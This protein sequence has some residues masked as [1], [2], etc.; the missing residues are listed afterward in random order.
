MTR[1]EENPIP[2]EESSTHLDHENNL[3]VPFNKV[4][5][6]GPE[7]RYMA[8]SMDAM[9]ISGDGFFTRKC[10]AWL[11]QKLGVRK[12]LL[13]TSGTHALELG[14]L[15][16]NL[17][18]GDEVIVPSFTFPSTVNA[19][20]L[21][22][23]VPVFADVRP[24]TANI[25]ENAIEDLVT[26][27]TRAIVVVHYAGV[28]CEMDAITAIA[29]RHGLTV[30]EDNA[31]GLFGRYKGQNLG[32]FG[33]FAAQS[34]HETKNIT[35][36]EGGALIIN[37]SALSERAEIIRE[38]GTNR[39]AFFRGQVDKYSW[40][41]IG[42]SYL[43]ADLLAAFLYAQLEAAHLIQARRKA[44]WQRYQDGLGPAAAAAACRLP[45]VPEEC[46]PAYHIFYL[47]MRSLE[48]RQALIAHLLNRGIVSTFHYTPLHSSQAG[49]KYGKPG[50]RCPVTD[51]ISARLVRLPFYAALDETHQSLVVEA[52]LEFWNHSRRA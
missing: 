46:E 12:V 20:A 22:G 49:L 40:V 37:D 5:L 51:D 3:A 50:A 8:E 34:F 27:R 10:H 1:Q 45:F 6:A 25:D 38:K 31:H 30:I 35:C 2:R 33:A 14:A 32:S 28:G 52:I 24:D 21:R 43:P 18:P 23:A 47:L 19:F 13:T 11:E 42:S 15:L 36:G 16:L 41:D 7:F 4:S 17:E 29:R 44:I 9:H 26:S 48:Q 39:A